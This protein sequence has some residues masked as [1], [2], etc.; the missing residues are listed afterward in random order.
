LFFIKDPTWNGFHDLCFISVFVA[1]F[2]STW[3]VIDRQ[4]DDGDVI[5]LTGRQRML[6]LFP[7][8]VS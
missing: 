6:T 3:I 1:M 2:L 8:S 4:K 5:N 7:F